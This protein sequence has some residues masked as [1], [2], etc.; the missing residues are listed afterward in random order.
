MHFVQRHI[1]KMPT[2]M[3]QYPISAKY[4]LRMHAWVFIHAFEI[5]LLGEVGTLNK[6]TTQDKGINISHATLKVNARQCKVKHE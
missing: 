1:Y 3:V 5:P 6:K 4:A 2:T